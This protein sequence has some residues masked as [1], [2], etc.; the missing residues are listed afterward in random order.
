MSQP[1]TYRAAVPSCYDQSYDH[2]S[3]PT[4]YNGNNLFMFYLLMY[5]VLDF[6]RKYRPLKPVFLHPSLSWLLFTIVAQLPMV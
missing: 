4:R 6:H 5:G 3:L 2:R 1:L